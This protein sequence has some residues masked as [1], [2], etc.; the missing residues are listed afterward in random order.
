MRDIAKEQT[1][2]LQ[3]FV[4]G[5]LTQIID[6]VAEAQTHAFSKGAVINP[7][8]RK[9]LSMAAFR[10]G[11]EGEE[12]DEPAGAKTSSLTLR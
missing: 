4:A 9:P 11:Q 1:M 3:A 7:A 10:Q 12:T 6:G 2:E 8:G 5:A